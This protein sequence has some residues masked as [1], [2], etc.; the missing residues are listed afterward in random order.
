MDYISQSKNTVAERVGEKK[1]Q[2]SGYL[3]PE[4]W[5]SMVKRYEETLL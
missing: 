4:V 5:R 3:G 1:N 2:N